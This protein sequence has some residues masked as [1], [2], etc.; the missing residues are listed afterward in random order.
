MW[1]SLLLKAEGE[2]IEEKA[3]SLTDLQ[4]KK[5]CDH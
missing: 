1:S 4:F 2:N 5:Y 3:Q